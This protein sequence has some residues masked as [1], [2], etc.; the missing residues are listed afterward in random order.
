MGGITKVFSNQDMV[1][2]TIGLYGTKTSLGDSIKQKVA[3]DDLLNVTGINDPATVA[4]AAPVAPAAV[5]A[6]PVSNDPTVVAAA[7]ANEAIARKR[8][9]QAT[10]R[11]AINTILTNSETLG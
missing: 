1:G 3:T 6:A 9:A 4:P 2:N 5:V 11:G 10:S 8:A 7:A